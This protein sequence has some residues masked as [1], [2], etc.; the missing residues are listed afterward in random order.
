MHNG[1]CLY[2]YHLDGW[3]KNIIRL[4]LVRATQWVPGRPGLNSEMLSQNKTKTNKKEAVSSMHVVVIIAVMVT[5]EVHE[6]KVLK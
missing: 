5:M 6:H 2:S 3:G 4:R 1:A